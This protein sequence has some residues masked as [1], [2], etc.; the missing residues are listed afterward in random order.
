MSAR[1]YRMREYTL[2]PGALDGSLP[3]LHRARCTTCGA[4][5]PGAP[6]SE[7]AMR[8]PH[9]HVRDHPRHLEYAE[10]ISRPYQLTPGRWLP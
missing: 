8:W 3:Q 6:G 2:S 7:E 10:D 4:A 9:D 1:V 5:G